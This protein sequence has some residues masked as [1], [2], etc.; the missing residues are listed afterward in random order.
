MKL[1]NKC[2][3]E[4]PLSEFYRSSYWKDGVSFYCKACTLEYNRQSARVA[5]R[6]QIER[7]K[8]IIREA[9]DVPCA[10]CGQR[11][12]PCAMDFDHRDPKK[13]RDHVGRMVRGGSGPLR[14]EIAKCDVVCACCHRIRTFGEKT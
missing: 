1:C 14:A 6:N 10:D 2:R 12:L 11:F 7:N 4:K 5:R 13:K 3:H 8:Q 9:K